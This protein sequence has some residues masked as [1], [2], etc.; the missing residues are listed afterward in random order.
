MLLTIIS[1]SLTGLALIIIILIVVRKFPALAILDVNNM[2]AEKEAKF[3]E[4]II[5][6]KVE[7]DLARWTG[8]LG[9]A[10]LFI[11]RRLAGF[12][13]SR[14]NRLRKIRISY[15]REA[16]MTWPERQQRLK[17]LLLAT[18]DLIKNEL[19]EEAEEKLLEAISLD[20]KNVGAFFKLGG[21]Y[22]YQKKWP[23][24]QQTYEHALKLSRQLK[25]DKE[26]LGEITPQEIYFSLS[27]VNKETGDIA[28]A[29]ENIREALDREPNNP[30]YLDLI[31]DLSI[32]K[33][34]KALALECW[35]KLAAVNPENNKLASRRE[36]IEALE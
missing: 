18:D 7:R 24:A 13:K 20:Q 17:T 26:A 23:E 14:Q 34:D 30:R 10:W 29:L 31:L 3:K 25:D 8:F 12:L 35:E 11:N 15:R 32:M 4:R 36:E 16:K 9:R 2:P 33:K 22:Q 1:L 5:K 28:A 19:A 6:Q 21:L 27:E